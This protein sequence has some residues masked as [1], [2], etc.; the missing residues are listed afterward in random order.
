M[1]DQA[2]DQHQTDEGFAKA[3][4][5]AQESPVVAAGA[6]EHRVITLALIGGEDGVDRGFIPLPLGRG[7]LMA[8]KELVQ[9]LGVDLE[10]RIVLNLALDDAE[11]VRRH[12]LPCFPMLLV[13][14]L[15]YRNRGAGDLDVQLNVLGQAGVS[16]VR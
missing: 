1:H 13:P 12:V 10:R 5:I 4:A 14:L 9:R 3:D 6:L 7:E 11:D 15:K 2:L 16:E 8:T